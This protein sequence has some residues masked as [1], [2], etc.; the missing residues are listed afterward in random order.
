MHR[1]R[2][3]HR[4]LVKGNLRVQVPVYGVVDL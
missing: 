4:T 3:S 2:G 1:V